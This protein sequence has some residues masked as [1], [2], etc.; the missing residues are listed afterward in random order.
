M[1]KSTLLLLLMLFTFAT[2]FSQNELQSIHFASNSSVLDQEAIESLNHWAALHHNTKNQLYRVQGFTDSRNS[3]AYNQ[4]LAAKRSGVVAEFLRNKGFQNVFEQSYGEGRQRCEENTPECLAMNRR[5]EIWSN[6]ENDVIS[7]ADFFGKKTPQVFRINPKI[8]NTLEGAEGTRVIIPAFAFNKKDTPVHDSVTVELTEFYNKGEMILNGLTTLSS[9]G[10]I[11]SAGT[12]LLDAYIQGDQLTLQ[13]G[14]VIGLVFQNRQ[15]NDGMIAFN[16]TSASF[17][18]NDCAIQGNAGSSISTSNMS[19]TGGV[20]WKSATNYYNYIF[21]NVDLY[22]NP[23]LRNEAHK[24]AKLFIDEHPKYL[25]SY[26]VSSMPKLSKQGFTESTFEV[27]GNNYNLLY[28]RNAAYFRSV[29]N[30]NKATPVNNP[31]KVSGDLPDGNDELITITTRLGWINCDRWL[32][33][34][35]TLNDVKVERP[36]SSSLYYL[37]FDKIQSIMPATYDCQNNRMVFR[38]IPV[39]YSA[40]LI[41][42]QI[43]HGKFGWGMKQ[44]T[45]GDKPVSVDIEP[46]TKQEIETRMKGEE[47]KIS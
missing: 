45:C 15:P 21:R 30:S 22:N 19:P 18:T 7:L 28:E 42:I 6:G 31:K 12:V 11:E 13:S 35:L 24:A 5:V 1:N 34:G 37:V 47:W 23:E 3:E 2:G 16:G 43:D 39:G 26:S 36:D 29:D 20:V 9:E 44:I 10:M 40:K 25:E 41:A 46:A 14:K 17:S 32:R 33:S 38:N 8:E 27:A 4:E